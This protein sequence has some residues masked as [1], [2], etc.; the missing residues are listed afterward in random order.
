MNEINCLTENEKL[1]LEMIKCDLDEK[2]ISRRLGIS[3]HTVNAH[4]VKLEKMKL[5]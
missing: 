1:V 2:E 5:I 4:K 3:K